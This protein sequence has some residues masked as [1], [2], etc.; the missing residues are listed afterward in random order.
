[1]KNKPTSSIIFL[2]QILFILPIFCLGQIPTQGPTVN[3]QKQDSVTIVWRTDVPAW[4]SVE[5]TDSNGK[6]ISV[7]KET[8]KNP[9]LQHQV[10]LNHLNPQT[11][12]GYYV[13]SNSSKGRFKSEWFPFSTAV[14]KDTPFR[15]ASLSDSRGKTNGVNVEILSKIVQKVIDTKS[16]LMIFE[17]DLIG[18]SVD[19]PKG[20]L[21]YDQW[22]KVVQ[23]YWQ[24]APIYPGVG[25]HEATVGSHKIIDR[26]NGDL[27]FAQE[28]TLPQNGPDPYKRIVYSFDYGNSHFIS[29]NSSDSFNRDFDNYRF[30]KI[31]LDWLKKDL[32]STKQLHKFIYF[33]DPAY[34]SG[35][36][37]GTSL[38]KYPEARDKFLKLCDEYGVEVLFCGHE[39][40]YDRKN[41]D[42]TLNPILHH[43]IYQVKNG[44]CGAPMYLKKDAKEIDERNQIVYRE[45]YNYA[46]VDVDGPKVTV[47]AYDDEGNQIDRFSYQD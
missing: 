14:K 21:E 31:Q 12:Y 17:G 6:M 24:S 39:H 45:V 29:L 3:L 44:T 30:N 41:L 20:I 7:I 37:I 23:P 32:A 36:H 2:F 46:I 35:T 40:N 47:T 34:P 16:N 22:K 9:L 15:F 25:S 27:V 19:V 4:G 10:T 13:L 33:H 18:G 43:T 1:M 8:G 11:D 42:H 26:P 38:D 28:F 5:Y